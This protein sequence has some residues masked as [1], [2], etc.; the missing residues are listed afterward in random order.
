MIAWSIHTQTWSEEHHIQVS[1]KLLRFC[2]EHA[3]PGD[4]VARQTD[5]DDLQ[6]GLEHEQS[7][8]AKVRMG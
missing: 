3:L 7:Q 1:E 2:I 6:H 5:A 8:V 4:N